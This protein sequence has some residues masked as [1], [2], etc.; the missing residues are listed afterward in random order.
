MLKHDNVDKTQDIKRILERLA[1][2]DS[3]CEISENENSVY[4]NEYNL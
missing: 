1:G 4:F 3:S 2:K